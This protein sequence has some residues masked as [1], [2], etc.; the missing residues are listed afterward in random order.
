MK[1]LLIITYY[2]PPTGGSGVQRWV[3]FSKYLPEFGW[4]PVIYTPENPEQL[5]VDESLLADIPAC[6]EII[7]TPIREPYDVWRKLT[8]GKPGAGEVNPV[9]AR[10]KSWKQRLALWVRGNCFIPDPRAGWV[11]P[12]LRYL[13][14]YLREHPV[15]AVVTTGPPQSMHLIGLGLKK[16]L[17]LPWIADFRDPWTEMFYYK[18][19]GLTRASDRRHHRLEQAVLDGADT[20][21]SVSPPVAADFQAKTNTPVVLITNGFDED[22]F[23]DSG[24]IASGSNSS[25]GVPPEPPASRRSGFSDASAG[26]G[27]AER[28]LVFRQTC[29]ENNSRPPVWK[30]PSPARQGT[31]LRLVHTGLF[32]ADGNPLNLWTVLGRRCEADPAFRERL[33]IRLAGK[34]DRAITDAIRDRG[35]GPNLVELGYLPHE[36]TVREQRE[37]DILLLP[38]RQEPEYAKVLPGKIFEYLAAGRPVLGIGQEDGAAA[39]ILRDAGAGQMFDWDKTD[40][41]LAFLDAEH[42]RTAGIEKY[43]RRALTAQLVKILP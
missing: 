2:W 36:Q 39:Q 22:D 26:D 15:D 6:A 27:Q 42:T 5:A 33:Q 40:A 13:E 19:L 11:R 37:A 38:L 31:S 30:T 23:A 9:N 20:V 43:S 24:E 14:R 18:H 17:G 1:R 4:Q 25:G 28:K 21:V 12:S 8:G 35:L 3:K 10:K 16:A 34:V 32:A 41:L 7:K 29:P